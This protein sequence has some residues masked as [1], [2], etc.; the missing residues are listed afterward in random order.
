M[1]DTLFAHQDA[2]TEGALLGYPRDLEL[3]VERFTQ[4]LHNR[5]YA[6]RVD[7]DIASADDS[8][9]AG[10]PTFFVNGRRH[11]GPGEY[12]RRRTSQ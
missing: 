3:D 11:Q 5:R 12:A 10:T 9:A 2:L 6:M 8:G 1:H 4:D 7:R